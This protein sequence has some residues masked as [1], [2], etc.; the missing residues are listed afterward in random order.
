MQQAGGAFAA[1]RAPAGVMRPGMGAPMIPHVLARA[2]GTI[3]S[4]PGDHCSSW[5]MGLPRGACWCLGSPPPFP[6]AWAVPGGL[7]VGSAARRARSRGCGAH[8][9]GSRRRRR[10]RQRRRTRLLLS[11]RRCTGAD[12]G[13]DGWKW[14]QCAWG[15]GGGGLRVSPDLARSRAP[16]RGLSG[17][18]QPLSR[19]SGGLRCAAGVASAWGRS[20]RL[21]E[22]LCPTRR[23]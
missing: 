3:A 9:R 17:R 7:A 18:W 1:G 8:R 21:A 4:R 2:L 22:V 15:A 23:V 12:S 6:W 16:E 11:G 13:N 19:G 5:P 20:A 14:L 10:R